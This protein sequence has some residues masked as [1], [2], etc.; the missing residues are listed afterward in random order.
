MLI[1]L[2]LLSYR[3]GYLVANEQRFKRAGFDL[4]LLTG[5]SADS[6]V[7]REREIDRLFLE[8]LA[9]LKYSDLDGAP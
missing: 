6:E 4:L 8:V 2:R 3:R 7:D 9:L 1:V 5:N